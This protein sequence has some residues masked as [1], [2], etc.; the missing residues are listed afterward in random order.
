KPTENIELKA[1][2]YIDVKPADYVDWRSP[3]YFEMQKKVTEKRSEKNSEL[4]NQLE[5]Q[6]YFMVPEECRNW[7]IPKTALLDVEPYK[8]MI[9]HAKEKKID[10]MVLGIRGHTLLNKLLV[11]STTDRIIRDSPCPVLAVRQ[12]E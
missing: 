11:G 9:K 1:S 3:D 10:M 7:C 6:L 12:V 5:Q 2:D 4:R 8:E